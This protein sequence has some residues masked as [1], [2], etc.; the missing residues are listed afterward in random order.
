LSIPCEARRFY[1]N[2]CLCL[3]FGQ[4]IDGLTM[5]AD[6]IAHVSIADGIAL[7]IFLVGWFGY[8]HSADYAAEDT[9]GVRAATNA[10]RLQWARHAVRRDKRMSDV[11]LTGNL[12]QNVSFYA[13]TTTCVIAG[14]IG[15]CAFLRIDTALRS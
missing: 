9:H 8:G 2:A 5:F 14:V 11:A 3:H 4:G 15:R 10:Y 7:A 12:M 6:L 1:R 13:S